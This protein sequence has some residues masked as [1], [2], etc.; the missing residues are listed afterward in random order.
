MKVETFEVTEITESG[1]VDECEVQEFAALSEQLGLEGQQ[2]FVAG[3]ETE[4]PAVV[5][6]RRM[7]AAEE[8]VYGEVCPQ[9]ITAKHYSD[10]PMPVRILQVL[11]H[12]T[13]L[14]FFERVEVWS[15]RTAALKD[16]VLVGVH[17]PESYRSENYILARWGEELDD[18]ATL[19]RKAVE[20]AKAR[21]RGLIERTISFA[22]ADLDALERLSA[23]DGP[24]ED[25]HY[26]NIR[27]DY[28]RP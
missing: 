7:T 4:A 28:N 3:K 10:R 23:E 15:A 22:K 20:A 17:K 14:D 18:F 12:A 8:F 13:A 26:K 5:P 6:Y 24:P 1:G 27:G 16:S 25:P 2:K 9:H 11:A 19:S 21:L